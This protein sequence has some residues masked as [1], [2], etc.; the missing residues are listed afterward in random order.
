VDNL[1]IDTTT[2]DTNLANVQTFYW[3]EP[4]QHS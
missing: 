3:D 4:E 2:R 1:P